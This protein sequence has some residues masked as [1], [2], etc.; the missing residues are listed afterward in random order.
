MPSLRTLPAQPIVPPL[1]VVGLLLCPLF[2]GIEPVGGD[3]DLMYRPIKAELARHLRQGRLPFWSDR[4][5]LG[6]PLAA[7]SHAAAF[8]P[9]NLLL[10]GTIG[11]PAAYRLSLWLHFVALAAASYGYGR[12]L[13]LSRAAAAL[14]AIGFPLCGFQAIHAAHEPFYTLMPYVPLC[15]LLGEKVLDTGR[16]I[17]AALLALAW[18]AQLTVGHF[19]IQMWTGGLV[20]ALGG[21]RVLRQGLAVA[22]WLILPASLA[23]GAGIA[24]V[25]LRLTW[26]LTRAVGFSRPTQLLM[27]FRFPLSHWAQWAM[28]ALYLGRPRTAGDTYWAMLGT[29]P[30]EACAYVGVAALL[31]ACVGIR[32]VPGRSTLAA[33]G[34]IAALAFALATMPTWC[35]WGFEALARIPGIGWFRAPARYTLLTSLGLILLAGRGLDRAADPGSYRRGMFLA[36]LLGGTSLAWW[37]ASAGDPLY[38]A[39]LGPASFG[40]RIGG[41]LLA[42]AVGVLALVCLQRR[43]A[44]GWLPA[45]ALATELCALFYLGPVAWGPEIDAAARSPILRRLAGEPGVGLV[46]GRLENLTSVLGCAAASPSLGIAAPPPTFLLEP[47]GHPPGELGAED[48]RWQ[49]RYGVTHGVWATTDDVS[50]TEVLAEL[51]DPALSRL[52]RDSS[53]VPPGARWRL[54][55]YRDPLPAAWAALRGRLVWAPETLHTTLAREDRAGEALFVHGDDSPRTAATARLTERDFLGRR[56][57]PRFIEIDLGRPASRAEVRGWDGREA[58]VEHDGACYLIL[59][60]AHYPGWSYRINGGPEH[61]P[62]KVNGGLQCV[63]LTGSGPSRVTLDYRPTGLRRAA[64]VSLLSLGAALLAVFLGLFR[65][66]ASRG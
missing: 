48:R 60:R 16:L 62:L 57:T 53:I 26:E 43:I 46:A 22:R 10:Y 56:N 24:W 6:V 18:G 34:W 13:G 37:L 12:V 50:G 21:W 14:V 66:R 11:T 5:G 61:P 8:Y 49:R 15:L 25:Q 1:V 27:N 30:E 28:P 47:S 58:T 20:L 9:P 35:P 40:L 32:A 38:R 51:D 45:A 19:Q 39:S 4:F 31:L 41:T 64:A 2:A 55:R 59:R 54:V 52:F 17:W 33:W 65:S 23:W 3:P 36:T 42:W 63:P 44:G 29:T 7:E